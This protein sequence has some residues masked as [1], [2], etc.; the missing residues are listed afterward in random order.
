MNQQERD[1]VAELILRAI[2]LAVDAGRTNGIAGIGIHARLVADDNAHAA[3][4]ELWEALFRIRLDD[5]DEG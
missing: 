4:R 3:Q 5:S 1:E 2:H